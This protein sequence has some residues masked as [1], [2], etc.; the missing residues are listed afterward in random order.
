ML[1][2]PARR[3]QILKALLSIDDELELRRLLYRKVGS[4]AR[5]DNPPE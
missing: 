2:R 5:R 1:N 4:D 3:A